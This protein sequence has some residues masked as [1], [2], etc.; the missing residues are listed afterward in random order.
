MRVFQ[1]SEDK[2]KFKFKCPRC[3]L[4]EEKTIQEIRESVAS[5][6]QDEATSS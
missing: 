6:A 5:E 2:Q 3:G 4:T 1:L